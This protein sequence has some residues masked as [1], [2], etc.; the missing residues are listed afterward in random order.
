MA[1][2]EPIK[3]AVIEGDH[4]GFIAFDIETTA[5]DLERVMDSD[6]TVA[7]TRLSS[8]ETLCWAS[9]LPCGDDDKGE[10]GREEGALACPCTPSQLEAHRARCIEIEGGGGLVAEAR[11]SDSGAVALFRYLEERTAAGWVIS[12]WNGA[13]FDFRILCAMLLRAGEDAMAKRCATIALGKSHIDLMFAF[14]ANRGFA[15]SLAKVAAAMLDG[16]GKSMDGAEAPKAW[17][18]SGARQ[19]EVALYCANDVLLQEATHAR[20]ITLGR[21]SW[22]TRKG[23]TCHWQALHEMRHAIKVYTSLGKRKRAPA[24]CGHEETDALYRGQHYN[25]FSDFL[26]VKSSAE[27]PEPDVGWMKRIEGME[28]WPRTKFIGWSSDTLLM[29]E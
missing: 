8:G 18:E 17:R 5:V 14:F 21:V 4:P 15:I 9:W 27:R 19:L 23:G 2:A 24:V 10:D 12:T 13:G 25:S 28:P 3:D 16:V 29:L 1:I 26:S 11:L 6:I 22:I 7:A 20:V